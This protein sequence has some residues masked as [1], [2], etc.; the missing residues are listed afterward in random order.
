MGRGQVRDSRRD[1]VPVET[2]EKETGEQQIELGLWVWHQGN[3]KT[4][5]SLALGGEAAC[6]DKRDQRLRRSAEDLGC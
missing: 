5:P 3:I 6:W 4:S 2:R 1:K